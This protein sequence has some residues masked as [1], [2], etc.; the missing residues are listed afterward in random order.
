MK[1]AQAR[2][3]NT[4]Q[5]IAHQFAKWNWHQ[6]FRWQRLLL[7]LLWLLSR[8]LW[9]QKWFI[10]FLKYKKAFVFIFIFFES[11]IRIAFMM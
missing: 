3:A 4:V 7:L 10:H 5:L 9:W 2:A 1:T 6:E 8:M 11:I